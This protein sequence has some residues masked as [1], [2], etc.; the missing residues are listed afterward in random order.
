M[1][2]RAVSPANVDYR[3]R[4]LIDRYSSVLSRL[5]LRRQASLASPA[6]H[7][8]TTWNVFRILA[9]VDPVR[10]VPALMRLGKIR[11]LPAP[12]D[13]AGGVALTLWKR[14]PPPAER[15]RWLQR[16]ALQGTVR[17]SVGGM[18]RGRVV[19]LSNL[20][21]EMREKALS[22]LP[23]EEPVEIDVIVKC[24]LSVLF[25]IVPSPAD[26]P[27]HPS[28][29]DAS[30][31]YLL[32]LVDSGLSYA[33]A[34]ARARRL[35]VSFSLLVLARTPEI[36]AS[37]GRA[38]KNLAKSGSQARKLFPHRLKFDPSTLSGNLGVGG[39]GSLQAMLEDLR[40]RAD[41]GMEEVLLSRLLAAEGASASAAGR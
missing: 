26:S 6:S 14:V 28:R 35:P 2:Q 36:E 5:P 41:N 4:L 7:D 34:R 16:Q 21:A 27:D 9:Q 24:P 30:R 29:S 11:A 8:A 40:R 18:R 39:W 33:E 23:L 37:W 13:L 17:P 1:P 15:I 32:R 19:P 10:W 31:T 25:L 12:R 38:V 20:R 22:R 3:D